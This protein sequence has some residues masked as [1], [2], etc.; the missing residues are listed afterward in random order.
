MITCFVD[1]SFMNNVDTGNWEF[2]LQNV[3][4]LCFACIPLIN[5][6]YGAVQEISIYKYLKT[7]KDNN[8]MR[9]FKKYSL[10]IGTYVVINFFIIMAYFLDYFI[11]NGY[12]INNKFARYIIYFIT[13]ITIAAPMLIGLLRIFQLKVWPGVRMLMNKLCRKKDEPLENLI[14]E[15]E[16]DSF[17]FFGLEQTAISK[18]VENIFISICFI[19][20]HHNRLGKNIVKIKEG[21]SKTKEE[22]NITKEKIL[23]KN[24]ILA[25]DSEVKKEEAFSIEV[26]E[27]APDIFSYLRKIDNIDADSMINSLLPSHNITKISESQ[28]ASGNFFINSS[29]NEYMI[30]TIEYDDVN[31][32]INLLI[33][34]MA[35]HFTKNPQSIIG[36]IYGL[37]RIKSKSGLVTDDS[38]YFI[39]MKNVFGIFGESV[40]CKYDLKGSKLN[41][42]TD[43]NDKQIESGVMKDIN[44]LKIEGGLILDQEYTKK[45][46]DT[47]FDDANF[48]ASLGIMDYSLL[49]VKIALNNDEMSALFGKF[50]RL[51]SEK[52]FQ[53]MMSGP[54]QFTESE[55]AMERQLRDVE[56]DTGEESKEYN[57]ENLNFSLKSVPNLKKYIF[58]SL[59]PDIMYI[60]AII[61]FFQLYN[62][63][64]KMET[65]FKRIKAEYHDISSADPQLYVNR[66]MENI[67]LISNTEGLLKV[68]GNP[69]GNNENKE[70]NTTPS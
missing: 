36:R 20:E 23:K 55:N 1:L 58:P 22:Y 29:D 6:I 14:P 16:Q 46:N 41:R 15:N 32:I 60:L 47:C 3:F 70:T 10:Y 40:L 13:L 57:K 51:D 52:N 26:E 17:G 49:V 28:G 56:K 24:S 59:K 66:F 64:K 44:F 65:A 5:F 48:L 37:Y 53:R 67:M 30:K 68:Q 27:F 39:L 62:F 7:Q 61:D 63:N 21:S 4:F 8:M 18:F 25:E 11:N 31:V 50:H 54:G 43:V 19:L 2:F 69:P 33:E 12:N 38:V 9:H 42:E 45:L 34:K 35:D